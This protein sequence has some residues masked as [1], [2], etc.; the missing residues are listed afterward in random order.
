VGTVRFA[1][2]AVRWQYLRC[3]IKTTRCRTHDVRASA[4]C[5]QLEVEAMPL[6]SRLNSVQLYC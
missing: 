1:F 2:A 5:L 4:E 3:M 6:F